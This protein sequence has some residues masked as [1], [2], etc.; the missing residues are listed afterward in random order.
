MSRL[1]EALGR[2]TGAPVPYIAV[3]ELPA[4]GGSGLHVHIK[5]HLKDRETAQ[6][7][8]RRLSKLTNTTP[9]MIQSFQRLAES[10]HLP[11]DVRG[12]E[13]F[14]RNPDAPFA[15]EKRSWQSAAYLC[16]SAA[17]DIEITIAG[18]STSLGAIR[19]PTDERK[20][21]RHMQDIRAY[22]QQNAD[23]S[24]TKRVRFSRCLGWAA[25]AVD[26]FTPD[27]AGD[28]G[29]LLKSERNRR[30]TAPSFLS[31]IAKGYTTDEATA[32]REASPG[33]VPRK[34]INRRPRTPE[35]SQKT[36]D[37]GI[38]SLESEAT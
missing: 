37:Y 23:I 6:I 18:R 10:N 2:D 27:K 12:E 32:I 14:V 3:Y 5:A 15:S 17:Q 22:Q 7:L 19:P 25:L 28:A 16:K 35:T 31:L 33:F 20:H 4:K 36:A 11:F 24:I 13:S 30:D 26:G 38:I 8:I 34:A 29:W 9:E 1:L 21:L